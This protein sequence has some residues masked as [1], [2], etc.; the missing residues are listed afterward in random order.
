MKRGRH[1]ISKGI[2]FAVLYVLYMRAVWTKERLR[3][4][5]YVLLYQ[6]CSVWTSQAT[7]FRVLMCLESGIADGRLISMGRYISSPLLRCN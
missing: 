1:Q 3:V 4:D 2:V 5:P 7:D 6:R